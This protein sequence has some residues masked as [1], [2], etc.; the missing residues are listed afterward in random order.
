MTLQHDPWSASDRKFLNALK[1]F[2]SNAP[3]VPFRTKDDGKSIDREL[4]LQYECYFGFVYNEADYETTQAEPQ[5][6]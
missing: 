3:A 5:G 1:A 6:N 4:T 2:C